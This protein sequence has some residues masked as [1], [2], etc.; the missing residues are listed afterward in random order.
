MFGVAWL[1]SVAPSLPPEET[2]F[3]IY[4][5]LPLDVNECRDNS[6]CCNQICTNKPG[7]YECSC[8]PGY[9]LNADNCTCEG[10]FGNKRGV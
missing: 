5:C 3:Y 1:L 4:V 9:R 2:I 6:S 10:N 7:S 8:Q